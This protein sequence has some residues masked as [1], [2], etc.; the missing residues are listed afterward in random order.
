[1]KTK[2]PRPWPHQLRAL[3]FAFTR[4]GS[5]LW[6][7]MGAGKTRTVIDYIQNDAQGPVLILCPLKVCPIWLIEFNKYSVDMPFVQ[8]L[9][10]GLIKDRADLLKYFNSTVDKRIV[11]TNYDACF[12]EPLCDELKKIKWDIIILDECHRIK[13]PMGVT[14]KFVAQLT[15]P[16]R[17]VIGL[18]GTPLSTGSRGK[19][20]KKIGAWLD[21]YGQARAIT[22]GTFGYKVTLFKAKYGIWMKEPFPKLL[23][24]Q[25][26]DDFN[27]RLASFVFHVPEDQ[28]SYSLPEVVEQIIPVFLP[29]DAWKLYIDLEDEMVGEWRDNVYIASNALVRILRLQQIAGGFIKQSDVKDWIDG[30]MKT[31]KIGD[32]TPVHTEK[33]DAISELIEDMAT[34]EKIVVFGKFTA[35]INALTNI[36]TLR[37]I[38]HVRGGEN[39]SDAWK[40]SEG[41]ILLVQ[42]QAGSEGIDLTAARYCIYCSLCHSMKDYQ[43]SRKRIH[44]PGQTRQVTYYHIVA[45]KTI[46]EVIYKALDTKREAVECLRDDL[47][48]LRANR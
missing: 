30:R 32:T 7:P 43:Q 21:I 29:S 11:V 45:Q 39:T 46:D 31:I 44:R 18:S 34:D 9:D 25:N 1:M 19:G 12:R 17:K 36:K 22:P 23:D 33:I 27:R 35:E 6:L 16:A 40:S 42:I 15:Q 5:L 2:G 4:R 10:H 47:M 13:A 3:R 38:Y 20:G 28:M 24:D 37:K 41:G 48:K 8:V 14:S 26:M